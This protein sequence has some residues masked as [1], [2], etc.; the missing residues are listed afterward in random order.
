PHESPQ[1]HSFP[2]RRSS[3]LSIP[4]PKPKPD[5]YLFTSRSPR[6]KILSESF[7]TLGMNGK[8]IERTKNHPFVLR[9]SKHENPFVT[10]L[11]NASTDRKSTRLNSSHQIISYA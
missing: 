10:T 4:P 9:L 7:D 11:L 5:Q 6:G 1:P 2:T 8:T 3:D